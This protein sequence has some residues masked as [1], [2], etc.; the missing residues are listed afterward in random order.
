[1]IS[2]L[3]ASTIFGE[4]F[5]NAGA[6]VAVIT[7]KEKLRKLL[8]KNLKKA[9]C[10]SSEKADIANLKDNR[11]ENVLDLVKKPL[12]KVYSSDLSEFI[13]AAAVEIL[14]K[15]KIDLMYLSTTDFIQHKAA[16]GDEM[17]NDFYH[18]VDGYLSKLYDLGCEISFTADH[19]MKRKN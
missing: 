8:G 12:P 7:A 19:G 17:A 5:E 2:F 3:R 11:I 16:P 6:K 1:M 4:A 10:F 15:E 18:I 14:K 9:I 13:F